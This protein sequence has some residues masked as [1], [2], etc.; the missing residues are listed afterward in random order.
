MNV[1]KKTS[2][3]L[4]VT[5]PVAKGGLGFALQRNPY[6]YLHCFSRHPISSYSNIT[7][8]IMLPSISFSSMYSFL[9]KAFGRFEPTQFIYI[10]DEMSASV[11]WLSGMG[12]AFVDEP[13]PR[14]VELYFSRWYRC[15][16]ETDACS[17][18]PFYDPCCPYALYGYAILSSMI[19]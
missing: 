8:S 11:Y 19:P 2:S 12:L 3:V 10:E 16:E 14:R 6:L 18:C 7:A 5:K 13:I 17:L 15:C 4:D 1:F 9:D